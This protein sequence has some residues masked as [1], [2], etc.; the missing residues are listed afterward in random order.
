MGKNLCNYGRV[1]QTTTR[2]SVLGYGPGAILE[3]E[4]GS[5]RE[6]ESL[7]GEWP[8]LWVNFSGPL[9]SEQRE[10][11]AEL[12]GL[13]ELAVEDASEGEER[14]KVEVIGNHLTIICR[15]PERTDGAEMGWHYDQL[16]LFL[17][18][19]A[20]ITVQRTHEDCLEHLRNHLRNPQSEMR[21]EGL[22]H[23]AQRMVEAVCESYYPLVESLGEQLEL[24]EDEILERRARSQ[25]AE[26]YRVRR[27]M[28]GARRAI[29]PLRET[30]QALSREQLPQ[31]EPSTRA[32]FRDTYDSLLILIDMV[33]TY[34]DMGSNLVDLHLSMV[35][36]RMN[37]IMKVLTVISAIFIPLSFIA[38]VYGMNFEWMPE[39]RI[40]SAYP[41]VL[42]VMGLLGC[43]MLVYFWRRGWLREDT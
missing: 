37:E 38:G 8:K 39:L 9:G 2:I 18:P 23:L 33:E 14:S 17:V 1:T 32:Y 15:T 34:R 21:L 11:L 16:T 43:G 40:R 31:I 35:N 7:R 12:F 5:V 10:A 13:H 36:N 20:L 29:W 41:I 3:H 26:L 28:L 4:L 22:D 42:A 6:L 24:L 27:V 25:I 30:L 19:G